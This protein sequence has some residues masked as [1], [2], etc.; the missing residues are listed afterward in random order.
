M[1]DMQNKISHFN[2][3]NLNLGQYSSDLKKLIQY[4]YTFAYESGP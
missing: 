2:K 4:I 3:N 1:Q